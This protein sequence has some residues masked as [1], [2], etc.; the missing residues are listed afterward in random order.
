LSIAGIASY[1]ALALVQAVILCSLMRKEI[2]ADFQQSAAHIRSSFQRLFET[3]LEQV[4]D[5]IYIKDTKGR[6]VYVSDALAQAHGH[7][8]RSELEGLSDFDFYDRE[9]AESFYAEEQEIL[10]TNQPVVNRVEKEIWLKDGRIAWV[11]VSK[12]PLCLDS[13]EAVGILGISRDV[14]EQQLMKEQLQQANKTMLDDL[15]SAERVQAVMIPGR[16]PDV[17]GVELGYVWKPM[18]AVGGDIINFPRNPE[19]DFLFFMGDVCGHGV[20]AAFYTVLLKYMTAQAAVDYQHSPSDFLDFVNSQIT[21]QLR[22]G[23]ITGIAGHFELLAAEGK[24]RLHVSHSGHPHLLVLR[25]GSRCVESIA[26]PNSM[27]MGLPGGSAAET[28]VIELSGGD[29]VFT[30]TDG[31]VEAENADGQQLG[32]KRL[33]SLIESNAALPL[34][35]SLEAVFEQVSRYAQHAGQQDDMTL[36]AFEIALT[37][38]ST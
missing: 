19:N 29:R 5:R 26:L 17:A 30:F 7:L 38:M 15:H 1:Y 11:S 20:Q 27:V 23:F 3:L 36:L 28:V 4:A 12:V 2:D 24:C 9:I 16:I 13:G 33:E 37:S 22:G 35:Q 31:A 6:F 14:T 25:R 10:R 8:H 21:S 32:F 18:G 34:Q